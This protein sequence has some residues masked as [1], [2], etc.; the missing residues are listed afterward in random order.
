[1]S[2][3]GKDDSNANKTKA[4]IGVSGSSQAKTIVFI[5]DTEAQLAENKARGVGSPGWYSFFTYTDMHGNTRYKSEQ[6]VSI[7]DPE[8]N[9]SETQS[10]DTIGADITSVIT[11]GT[12]AN[13][14]TFAPAG[15]VATFSDNGG[16]DGSRTAGTYTVTNAAGNASGTG[17]DFSV[18]VAA[19]GTPTVTLVSGGTGYADNETITIADSSLGGGGGAAVVVTVTAAATAAAT[20]TLSGASST[21]SGASLTYQW[22]RAEPGSTNFKDLS[23]K[24]SANTGSLTGLTVAA[25][26]GAQYRCVVNNSIGGVTKTSTAGTLTVTDRA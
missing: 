25:D 2:L 16:A 21:G 12:V 15:A 22:Q 9:A 13:V 1:M 18:V 8:A 3:Y 10:D 20:F 5:D 4:G 7:T 19:N 26:N 11:P 23:G 14:T 17:A 6:L 24:T